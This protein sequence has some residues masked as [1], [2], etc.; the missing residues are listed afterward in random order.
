MYK[1]YLLIKQYPNH[2]CTK[3]SVSTITPPQAE[4][5]KPRFIFT[6]KSSVIDTYESYSKEGFAHIL[7]DFVNISAKHARSPYEEQKKFLSKVDLTKGPILVTVTSM[8]RTTAVDWESPKRERKEYFYYT[9]D[10]EA[11]DRLGNTIRCPHE[12]EGKYTQQTKIIKTKLNPN[13]E[14]E[15]YYERGTPRDVYAIPW[16]KKTA[17]ELLTSEKIFGEDSINITNMNEVVYIVK[18]PYGN[19]GRT[20]FEMSDFLDFKYEKLQ[21][22]SKTVK[23]PYLADLERRINP[24]K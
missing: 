4:R 13:G 17:N 24:Y 12:N 2:L 10:W 11:K 5:P 14:E 1:G 15:Q 7:Q 6:E 8:V 21:E 3:M 18:F 19:P 20:G 23:S 9:T 16:N 22:L